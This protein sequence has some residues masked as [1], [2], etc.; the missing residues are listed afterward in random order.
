[1][2]RHIIGLAAPCALL[3]LATASYAFL[4]TTVATVDASLDS[5]YVDTHFADYRAA[6][7]DTATF[8]SRARALDGVAA[9]ESRTTST[10]AVWLRGGTQKLQGQIIGVPS[11][12]PPVD[13]MLLEEGRRI[14]PADPT[15]VVLERHTADDLDLGP[16][17]SLRILGLGG[18]ED[19]NVRGV[20]SSPEYVVPAASAQQLVTA[21]GS[22]AVVFVPEALAAQLPGPLGVPEVLVRYDDGASVGTLDRQLDRIAADTNAA[23]R[24]PRASQPSNAMVSTEINGLKAARVLVPGVLL[25]L[26]LAI[27]TFALGAAAPNPRAARIGATALGLGGA[28]GLIVGI[29]A[30]PAI[31]DRLAIPDLE[32]GVSWVGLAVLVLVSAIAGQVAAE[33]AEIDHTTRA[34]FGRVVAAFGGAA[35]GAAVIIAP[36]GIVDAAEVTLDAAQE[37][38]RV[39]AQ[40]AFQTVVGEGQLAQLTGIDG[41][42]VAESVPSANVAIGHGRERY[43]TQIEAFDRDTQLQRFLT[44]SGAAQRLPRTGVL[45]PA[46]LAKLLQVEPGEDVVITIPGVSDITMK[47]SAYT[48]DALGNL[49]FTT[50]PALREAMGADADGFAGGLFSVAAAGFEPGAD[51]AVLQ[52]EISALSDVAT[53]VNV[54]G[55]VGALTAV[56]PLFDIVVIVLAVLG[57]L[58]ALAGFAT[59]AYLVPR[60]AGS[61]R[62]V[63]LELAMPSTIGVV[64]GVLLGSAIAGVLVDSL[65][66]SL[67]K[68]EHTLDGST[69]LVALGAVSVAFALVTFGAT[70]G[71]LSRWSPPD[72]AS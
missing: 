51:P 50:T 27:G 6:D 45:L 58:L 14:D 62:G 4:S 37:L 34:R 13:G 53:Y 20:A 10:L 57:G 25:V 2:R 19:V 44:P 1:V 15:G 40:V 9:V 71:R 43:L 30:A 11:A 61:R 36:L 12:R 7:G 49:V 8:A 63:A 69:V 72:S 46:R 42:R 29:A 17:D 66:T 68:L 60:G 22:F 64:V 21:R 67:V 26:A 32:V 23:L 18:I 65:E 35:I 47:V 33:V 16:G 59:A 52:R 70:R 48:S 54:E 41:V 55:T 38:E 3:F 28:V 56:L 24:E 31:T 39:D 5:F